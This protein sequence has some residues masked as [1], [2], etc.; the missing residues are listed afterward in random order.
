MFYYC[1]IVLRHYPRNGVVSVFILRPCERADGMALPSYFS[2]CKREGIHAAAGSGR[3]GLMCCRVSFCGTLPSL[4]FWKLQCKTVGA[5][6]RKAGTQLVSV[7]D[8]QAAFCCSTE[9]E[10]SEKQI[11]GIVQSTEGHG[12]VA[13]V[14]VAVTGRKAAVSLLESGAHEQ[15]KTMTCCCLPIA[16][17]PNR[18][19]D[20]CRYICYGTT[21][22]V[23]NDLVHP[24]DPDSGLV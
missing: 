22:R 17:I 8:V 11:P 1:I 3:T 4:Y 5:R 23:G 13:F 19:R 18:C 10:L 15:Q 2:L 9:Q 12:R 21:D 20:S 14:G 24:V 6:I 7:P 16:L